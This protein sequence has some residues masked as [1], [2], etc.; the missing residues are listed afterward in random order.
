[1]T[2][3]HGL[4]AA[5]EG[6][7]REDAPATP[8]TRDEAL[9]QRITLLLAQMTVEDKVA[10]MHG[11]GLVKGV[12]RTPDNERLGIPGFA[13]VDGPRGV[14]AIAGN[15]TAFP[16][17]MARGATWDTALEERV[18]EAIGREAKAR[19][20]NVLLAPTINILRH[21]RWGRA[22]E[23]YG[24]DAVHIGRM[25]VAFIRGAQRHVIASVKHFAV[26]SIENVRN[27]VD[28]L[29]DERTL[30]EVYLPHFRMAVEDARVGSVM[31]AYN[32]VNGRYCAENTHLLRDILKGEWGFQGFVESDWDLGT[33]ST[34]PS[35]L[36]G[37]DIEMPKP[38]FY[39]AALLA[40]VAAGD[41]EETVLDD[42]VRRILRAKLGARLETRP[43]VPE[44][45]LVENPYHV[46]L[47]REVARKSIVL[48]K[49]N[50]G[51][52]PIDPG[53]VR[54]IAVVGSLAALPNIGDRGSS[55][56]QPSYV[57]TAVDGIRARAGAIVVREAAT[58]RLSAADEL[59][60]AAADLVIVVAGLTAD[61]EG[62]G[63]IASGD[64]RDLRLPREQ[65]AL[66]AAV[67][68]LNRRTVVV[69]E[70][71]AALTMPWADDVTAILMAWYPGQEG[72]HAIAEVLFG[73]VN[74]SGRLPVSFPRAESDLPEFVNDASAVT[75]GYYHGY[76]HLDREGVEALFPFGFGLSYTRFDYSNLTLSASRI[77]RDGVLRVT[78]D[79][80]NTGA[81][82]GEEVVQLYISYEGSRVDR[83][84]RDLKGFTRVRL[85]PGETKTVS[86]DLNVRDLAFFDVDTGKWEV[87]PISYRV[88]VG[89]SSAELSLSASFDIVPSAAAAAPKA[90]SLVRSPSAHPAFRPG[91][92]WRDTSGRAI[93]AHG[94]GLLLHEGMYYWFG[95]HKI[96]GDEGNRAHVGVHVYRSRDLYDWEDHGIA[97]SVLDHP[98]TELLPGCIVERPKV[99]HNRKTGKFVMW[100]HL[101]PKG[102]GYTAAR[103]GVAVSESP[104]GPYRFLGSLRPNARVWPEN[105]PPELRR[106]LSADEAAYLA[107]LDPMGLEHGFPKDLFFRRDFAE[108]QMARDLTLFVDDDGV[109]YHIYAS[110]ENGVLHISQ[111]SDDYLRPAGRYVRAL[112]GGFHEAP[113]LMKWR[114]RYFLFTSHCTGWKP[115]PGRISVADSIWGPWTELGNPCVG[116]KRQLD[117]TFDAQPTYVQPLAG[118]PDAYVFMAD[119]WRPRNAIDG[120]YVWLPVNLGGAAPSLS[121]LEEWDLG[122]FNR[123]EAGSLPRSLT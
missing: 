58:D 97:L 80:T 109:G 61:E 95:E 39:G 51:I 13:M 113:A 42:A 11:R 88:W 84:V 119:R 75:Y 25:G 17:S 37:L 102:A 7:A 44:P 26:N 18:G 99:V 22:Q 120:R 100:F 90:P 40:A 10:Q 35:A 121:W 114:G 9:E 93:N 53:R 23:T 89:P 33:R 117:T 104:S 101:E 98:G 118:A 64:R 32:K 81:V 96:A 103:S 45:A 5:P 87:E 2:A 34:A 60:V 92:V 21:P 62:E 27:E 82:F 46:A 69:L 108:G 73:D 111:L 31:L 52:L 54:T 115:N 4:A 6:T 122:W 56:V 123:P 74:P 14:T 47:A 83:A 57:V 85:E 71:G 110:E 112:P 48:L 36:A 63:Q 68:K 72:G 29:V 67:A 19:T 3:P 77:E 107:S 12:F 55:R 94:G 1:M 41:V 28:V 15:G 38:V 106:E 65:D 8:S 86:L 76:R 78:T 59:T 43:V 105:A 116:T 24:E 70:G 30:R 66:I 16:V 91:R 79:V 49:N 20:A 50:H